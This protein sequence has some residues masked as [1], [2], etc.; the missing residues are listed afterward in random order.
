MKRSRLRCRKMILWSI[1]F[2]ISGQMFSFQIGC[3]C[4]SMGAADVCSKE[5]RLGKISGSLWSL[6]ACFCSHSWANH[7]IWLKIDSNIATDKTVQF[8]LSAH[9]SEAQTTLHRIATTKFWEEQASPVG[10]N[11]KHFQCLTF[12]IFRP[13]GCGFFGRKFWPWTATSKTIGTWWRPA[14]WTAPWRSL[15]RAE[16]MSAAVDKKEPP[17]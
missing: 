9:L 5:I 8:V 4:R 12:V 7:H 3:P 16:K 1:P 2:R 13:V 6:I 17:G 14:A 15:M 10:C 11:P